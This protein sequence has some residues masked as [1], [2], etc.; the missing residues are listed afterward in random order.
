MASDASNGHAPVPKRIV[1][2]NGPREGVLTS[3]WPSGDLTDEV[4]PCLTTSI[5]NCR[6]ELREVGFHGSHGMVSRFIAAD[7]RCKECEF[8]SVQSNAPSGTFSPAENSDRDI[9]RAPWL[10]CRPKAPES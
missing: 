7:K 10:C 3:E 1:P 2:R 4:L 5:R 9:G 6:V 8:M